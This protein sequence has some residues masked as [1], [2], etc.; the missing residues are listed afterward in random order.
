MVCSLDALSLLVD[1]ANA[2]SSTAQKPAEVKAEKGA[3]MKE[4]GSEPTN[5]VPSAAAAALAL[6]NHRAAEMEFREA[7][8][9]QAYERE[10]HEREAILQQRAAQ[11]AGYGGFMNYG[12][13]FQEAEYMQ[14][15][16]LEALVQQRRQETLAQLAL[17]QEYNMQPE[18]Q[19]PLNAQQV[20]QATMLRAL[21]LFAAGGGLAHPALEQM[22]ALRGRDAP[23][24]ENP[25]LRLFEQRDRQQKLAALGAPATV[26]SHDIPAAS[27]KPEPVRSAAKPSASMSAAPDNALSLAGSKVTVLPCRA[28]GMPMDHNAKVHFMLLSIVSE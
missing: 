27:A 14:Q 17:A 15:L 4:Q 21:E 23:G 11:M 6:Q 3:A 12:L 7:L 28:R 22:A 25:L 20:R 1:A 2:Q 16:R 24:N 8:Q 5:K 9:R 26:P 18:V 19:V 10:V 13:Q